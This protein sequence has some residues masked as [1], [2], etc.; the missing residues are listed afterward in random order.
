MPP[1]VA[2]D[3]VQSLARVKIGDSLP[4]QLATPVS[5][6][7][8]NARAGVEV[9]TARGRIAARGVIVTVSTGVLAAGKIKFVPELPRRQLDAVS[10]LGLGSYDRV[11]LELP[12]NPLGLERDDLVFQKSDGERTAAVLANVAG[13]RLVMVDVGG[14]F[15]RELAAKGA[16]AMTRFALD[17]LG[18]LYG[19]DLRKSVKR[20]ATTN[21][22]AEPWALGAFSAAA[23]GG[24]PS[25][26]TLMEPVRERLWFAGEAVHE[27]LWGTVGGAWES[28]ER[29]ADAALKRLGLVTQPREPAPAP[30]ATRRRR[31]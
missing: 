9:E 2:V 25:R 1:R 8:L 6:I 5:R 31:R 16:D 22:N 13:A 17:W 12:D 20:T 30:T 26:R 23:P 27:T 15:G 29:A 11:V 28:G 18:D 3:H 24:Q 10:S 21:W 4:A 14:R 19:A 7:D